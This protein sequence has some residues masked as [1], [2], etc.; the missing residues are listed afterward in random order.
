MFQKISIHD[1]SKKELTEVGFSKL[2]LE[3]YFR[4]Y[5]P[6]EDAGVYF[7]VINS[8]MSL[9]GQETR[10]GNTFRYGE[11]KQIKIAGLGKDGVAV[12]F[13]TGG[14]SSCSVDSN[15]IS[16]ESAGFTYDAVDRVLKGYGG[17]LSLT[18]GLNKVYAKS[19]VLKASAEGSVKVGDR[20]ITCSM[21]SKD[22]VI[23]PCSDPE[24][25]MFCSQANIGQTV[26][27]TGSCRVSYVCGCN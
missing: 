24:A 10:P 12:C 22:F 2:H 27:G 23:G 8:R 19:L 14:A 9:F 17:Q 11:L 13:E 20:T 3:R 18:P 5:S 26:Q 15:W 7:G 16:A 4:V 1:L 21:Q 25:S 6:A